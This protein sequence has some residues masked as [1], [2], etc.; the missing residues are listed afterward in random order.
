MTSNKTPASWSES[1]GTHHA[2]WS[3]AILVDLYI[4]RVCRFMHDYSGPEH[5]ASWWAG[6]AR[7]TA[8]LS[9]SCTRWSGARRGE[10]GWGGGGGGAAV[11][12]DTLPRKTRTLDQIE[13]NRLHVSRNPTKNYNP[14]QRQTLPVQC[15]TVTPNN[16]ITFLPKNY[17][18]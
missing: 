13:I 10:G 4:I 12:A 2:S 11:P 1:S 6:P 18:S 17:Q 15:H 14:K 3:G 5:L 9:P 8:S 16:T 7:T